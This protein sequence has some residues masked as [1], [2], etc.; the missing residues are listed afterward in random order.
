MSPLM[1]PLPP[2]GLPLP[3]HKRYH[4]SFYHLLALEPSSTPSPLITA[5][6]PLYSV[7]KATFAQPI[8]SSLNTAITSRLF[9]LDLSTLPPT[10]PPSLE[11]I[12][13]TCHLACL[14]YHSRP[15]CPN[16]YTNAKTFTLRDYL[17]KSDM[18]TLWAPFPGA[19][20]WCLI[21]GAECAR[22]HDTLYTWFAAQLMRCWVPLA[23][24]RWEGL[25]AALEWFGRLV[26]EQRTNGEVEGEIYMQ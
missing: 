13:R 5:E 20:L 4:T 21:V 14:M 3:P 8:T 22:G 24:H 19:L 16:A 26:R 17:V 12:P 23:M 6:T 18:S 2:S 25:E 15:T 9:A 10:L 7:L 1:F 11:Y